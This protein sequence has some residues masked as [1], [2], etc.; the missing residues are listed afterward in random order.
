MP[1]AK[2]PQFESHFIPDAD[3]NPPPIR[4]PTQRESE[5]AFAAALADAALAPDSPPDLAELG[6]LIRVAAVERAVLGWD[7]SLL[8]PAQDAAGAA[9]EAPAAAGKGGAGGKGGKRRRGARA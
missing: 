9:A 2:Q 4:V 3:L 5:R 1:R 6:E 8:V 7:A